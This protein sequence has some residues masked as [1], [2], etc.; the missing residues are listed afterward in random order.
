LLDKPA[1]ELIKVNIFYKDDYS[2]LVSFIESKGF[3]VTTKNYLIIGAELSRELILELAKRSE[4]IT[5]EINY[6]IL[7]A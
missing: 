2:D 3:R 6:P 5:I 4:I 7:P 1:D